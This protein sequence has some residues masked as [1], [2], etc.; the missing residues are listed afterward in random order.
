MTDEQGACHVMVHHLRHAVGNFH[1]NDEPT[2]AFLGQQPF[3]D[4]PTSGPDDDGCGVTDAVPGVK[5]CIVENN[6]RFHAWHH[7]RE[8]RARAARA[9]GSSKRRG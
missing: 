3:G 2:G 9:N 4:A 8:P 7:S 6:T 1:V 5:S